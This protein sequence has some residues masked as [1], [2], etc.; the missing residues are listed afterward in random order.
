[1]SKVGGTLEAKLSR[2]ALE[3]EDHKNKRLVAKHELMAVLR[4]L[5]AERDVNSRLRESIKVTFTPKALS[6][7]QTIQETLDEFEGALQKLA[8]RLGRPLPPP[9]VAG[10]DLLV[11]MMSEQTVDAGAPADDQDEPDEN[12]G[13]RGKPSMSEVS[14]TRVLSKLESETQRVSQCIMSLTG[15]VERMHA[16]LDSARSRGCVDALQQ[17]LL[18]RSPEG[19]SNEERAA[20]TGSR[21]ISRGPRYGQVP[22]TLT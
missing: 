12:V 1:M 4:Q 7:Q 18:T 19:A 8:T 9:P 20:M 14:T 15:S 13:E 3:T 21:R 6:Q 5:E 16:L 17:L 22:G 2:S 10:N 11:E